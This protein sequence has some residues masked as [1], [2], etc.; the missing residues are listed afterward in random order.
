[1]ISCM[2]EISLLLEMVILVTAIILE[3]FFVPVGRKPGKSLS[4]VD[5]SLSLVPRRDECVRHGM[6][7]YEEW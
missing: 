6:M 5:L 2:L 1:M 3:C 4:W 7:G